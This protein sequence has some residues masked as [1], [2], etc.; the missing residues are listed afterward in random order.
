MTRGNVLSSLFFSFYI[1][2]VVDNIGTISL[3][4][5]LDFYRM[6]IVAYIYFDNILLL[7][8]STEGLQ[9]LIDKVTFLLQPLHS[10]A[11]KNKSKYIIFRLRK[12]VKVQRT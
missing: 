12:N 4:C 3:G 9:I 11:D 2:D 7:S 8:P 10:L 1:K 6:N 5:Q